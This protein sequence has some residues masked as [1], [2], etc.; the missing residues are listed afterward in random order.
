M[1]SDSLNFLFPFLLGFISI[2]GYDIR[3]LNPYWLRSQIGT[4]SQVSK[5]ILFTF[6]LRWPVRHTAQN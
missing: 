1:T 5:I 3:D 2:D 4:V 6:L